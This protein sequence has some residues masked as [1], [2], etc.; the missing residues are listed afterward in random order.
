MLALLPPS[1]QMVATSKGG[2]HTYDGPHAISE[3]RRRAAHLAPDA[4]TAV[5]E[6]ALALA[7]HHDA[8]TGTHTANVSGDYVDWLHVGA[9]KAVPKLL[10]G[11]QA[12]VYGRDP[13]ARGSA[14]RQ[15]KQQ[16]QQKAVDGAATNGSEASAATNGS[17]AAA[18]G[19]AAAADAAPRLAM[20]MLLNAS[21]CSSSVQLSKGA[22]FLLVAYNPLSWPVSW[23]VR[24]PVAEGAYA[25]TGG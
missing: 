7:H 4:D 15:R 22:G 19:P 3:L 12:L 9:S 8:I 11:L 23:G 13:G 21:V 16:K 20:C 18:A 2:R 5:L 17:A 1:R 14:G 6:F 10:R 25:V 24:V